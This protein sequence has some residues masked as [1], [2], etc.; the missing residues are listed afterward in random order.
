MAGTDQDCVSKS[1]TGTTRHSACAGTFSA[2]GTGGA[3]HRTVL[4]RDTTMLA[5]IRNSQKNDE[6]FTLIE[7]L[8]VIVIIGILA[9]VAIP[10]FLKQKEKAV[11]SGL[12]SDLN[13]VSQEFENYYVDNQTYPTTQFTASSTTVSKVVVGG[14]DVKTSTNNVIT[15]VSSTASAYCLKASNTNASKDWYI[16]STGGLS[17][18]ACT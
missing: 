17:A 11:E 18:T 7:L 6:G 3:V 12:K 8:V 1:R 14:V 4:G 9:A 15:K 10:T 16:S 5:R 2:Q 13:T